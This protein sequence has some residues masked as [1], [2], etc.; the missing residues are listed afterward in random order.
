MTYLVLCFR[1]LL[2]MRYCYDRHYYDILDTTAA[3]CVL[4]ASHCLTH[5]GDDNS[6]NLLP[7]VHVPIRKA[8]ASHYDKLS[9]CYL[10]RS[11]LTMHHLLSR[12]W[13]D[14]QYTLA[15]YILEGGPNVCV[16]RFFVGYDRLST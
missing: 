12:E 13:Y 7:R 1:L 6:Y 4:V 11:L 16:S 10:S 2:R 3:L 15:D 5:E 9:T 8:R 14:S